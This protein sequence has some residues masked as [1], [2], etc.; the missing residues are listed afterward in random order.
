MIPSIATEGKPLHLEARHWA[1]Y[2]A[3]RGV[4]ARWRGPGSLTGKYRV[5]AATA[6]RQSV[7]RSVPTILISCARHLGVGVQ[8]RDEHDSLSL[9]WI[10]LEISKNYK[11][12]HAKI[13]AKPSDD[14]GELGNRDVG[15]GR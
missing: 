2:G 11:V 1:R 15:V 8:V 3:R 12:R 13:Y 6:R 7:L 5:G 10:D 4:D 9:S 14:R